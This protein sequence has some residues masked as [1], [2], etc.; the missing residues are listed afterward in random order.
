M[1]KVKI[2]DL[3]GNYFNNKITM[4]TISNIV[5]KE[6]A[7][8]LKG[9]KL[10]EI[11]NFEI[12][13][14]LNLLQSDSICV[15]EYNNQLNNV[16]NII[17]GKDNYRCNYVINLNKSISLPS[18][19]IIIKNYYLDYCKGVRNNYD[20][21]ANIEINVGITKDLRGIILN[22]LFDL[23]KGLPV[24]ND[25][26]VELTLNMLCDE[27]IDQNYFYSDLLNKINQIF[28]SYEGNS[29]LVVSFAFIKGER[30]ITILL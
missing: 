21:I 16:K 2:L 3:I 15:Q 25:A 11:D 28:L 20:N 7:Y 5:E 24:S 6:I 19:Y 14:L 1:D 9:N 10:E 18:E 22:I 29:T 13:I 30:L 26:D 4:N 17:C 12:Y 23:I 27:G 8:L